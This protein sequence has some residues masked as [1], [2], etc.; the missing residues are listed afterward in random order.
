ML[1][2]DGRKMAYY[3]NRMIGL[4]VVWMDGW[5]GGCME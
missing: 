1:E 5:N 4:Y 2:F 3:V